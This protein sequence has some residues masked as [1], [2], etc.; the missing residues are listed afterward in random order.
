MSERIVEHA[1]DLHA[2]LNGARV[3]DFD[4]LEIVGMAATLALHI[5]GLGSIDYNVMRK[6]SD[7]MMGIPSFALP[8]VLN[9][10]ADAGFVRLL[11]TGKT[12]NTVIPDVP[13]FGSVYEGLGDYVHSMVPINEH[14]QAIVE[15]LST[16]ADAPNNRDTVFNKLGVEKSVFDRTL[17]IGT[18]SGIVNSQR[19]RG[20]EI[21][22]SPYHF[23]DNLEGLADTA[24]AVGANNLSAALK[25]VEANQGWPLSLLTARGEIGQT[26]L[27]ITEQS[28]IARLASEGMIK[29]PT[30]KFGDQEESFL[31]TP[32]PGGT[33]L[34][35]SNREI[36]ER[37]MALVSAVRKGQLLPKRIAIRS[38]LAILRTLRDS[39]YLRANTEAGNQYQ[40]LVRL[41]VGAL[42][43]VGG[44]WS[45]FHINDTEEN[46]QALTLAI[47]LLSTGTM[48]GMEVDQEARI[49]LSK[50]DQYIQSLIASSEL[51]KRERQIRD[52]EA[53]YEFDQL[54]L[55]FD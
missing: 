3:P 45:Q 26:K 54:I 43:S 16:L 50:D 21:L 44:G 7:H 53:D 19:A 49:A 51:K 10:L 25:K 38:P 40:N 47:Q 20:R 9:I 5:K 34:N 12:I 55:K 29:P 37:A 13:I 33:R 8:A 28:L 35:A 36:Y 31:F 52:E 24:A 4:Q 42:R 11:T 23:V 14:E 2:G 46:Q 32:K 22:I 48:S 18:A 30:I 15:L 17:S 41:R 6:V 27:N 1:Y 39:G